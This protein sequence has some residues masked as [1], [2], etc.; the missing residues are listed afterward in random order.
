MTIGHSGC[1]RFDLARVFVD[2][3]L[4]AVQRDAVQRISDRQTLDR[5]LVVKTRRVRRVVLTLKLP[6]VRIALILC[7]DRQ[8]RLRNLQRSSQHHARREVR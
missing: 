8:R 7:R 4:P 1:R 3:N 5:D 6:V 2:F